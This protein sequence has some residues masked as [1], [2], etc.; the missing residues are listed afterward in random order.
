MSL[1]DRPR[2]AADQARRRL[3]LYPVSILAAF[4]RESYVV[5]YPY[6]FLRLLGGARAS[7]RPRADARSRSCRR[8]V[9]VGLRVAIVPDHPDSLSPTSATRWR[10]ACATGGAA[11]PA[12]DRLPR[13][14]RSARAALPAPAPRPG[15]PPPG[16]PLRPLLLW[17]VPPA[18]NTERELGYTLP[19]LLPAALLALRSLVPRPACRSAHARRRGRAPGLLLLA[20]ALSRD[21]LQHAPAHEPRRRRG[22]GGLSGSPRRPRA[23]AEAGARPTARRPSRRSGAADGRLLE[24]PTPSRLGR[25]LRGCGRRPPPR[26]HPARY[27]P[28]TA[29]PG[30]P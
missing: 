20:A 5:V 23:D 13:R 15:A 18:N 1:P 8:L 21:G 27:R 2:A 17:P 26:R 11:V 29:R 7:S 19:V 12:D 10:C 25:R 3:W 24:K 28:G 9:L 30:T 6:L 22:D 4:V 16:G 14:L